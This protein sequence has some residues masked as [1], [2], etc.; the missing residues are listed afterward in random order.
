[1]TPAQWA[2]VGEVILN[3]GR[4][5]VSSALLGE[6]LQGTAANRAFGIGFWN[7]RAAPGGREVDV[8]QQL[9][10]KWHEQDWSN[11]C[12]CRDAPPDLVVGLG[13]GS[14]R[15]Y[16]IP[17]IELIVVRFGNFGRFSDATFLRMLLGGR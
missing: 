16:V 8:E 14:Q 6:C 5:I 12:I 13:S 7:N 4:P 15:L 17:S 9:N 2:R 10:R 3:E 11:A 1:M